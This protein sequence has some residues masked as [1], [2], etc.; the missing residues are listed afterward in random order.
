LHARADAGGYLEWQLENLPRELFVHIMS[1]LTVPEALQLAST[2]PAL[3]QCVRDYWGN[4]GSVEF[5]RFLASRR[6]A[7]DRPSS[8]VGLAKEAAAEAATE[9]AFMTP[10]DLLV[11][12]IKSDELGSFANA[13]APGYG[14]AVYT[15]GALI[16]LIMGNMNSRS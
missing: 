1:F 4:E 12:I 8:Y 2:S 5:K 9:V 10:D 13:F 14:R 11:A 16:M 3:R 15:L 7:P 6:K